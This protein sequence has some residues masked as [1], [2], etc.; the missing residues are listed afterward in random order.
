MVVGRPVR[1]RAWPATGDASRPRVTRGHGWTR[2]GRDRV[3]SPARCARRRGRTAACRA[4]APCRRPRTGPH[5]ACRWSSWRPSTRTA[6]WAR[7]RRASEVEMPNARASS[8]GRWTPSP[9]ASN[10]TTGTSSGSSCRMW[11]WSNPRS[12]SSPAP[13]PWKRVTNARAS[14]RL[15]SRGPSSAGG[16]RPSRSVYHDSI[17]LSG[18]LIVFPY[19]SS[20]GSV[21]PM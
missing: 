3:R 15:A 9:E 13:S 19:I 20:G 12:A 2:A 16:S 10:S 6:P 17:A 1:W 8:A 11:T 7:L 18:M 4:G 21:T 14:A 5:R